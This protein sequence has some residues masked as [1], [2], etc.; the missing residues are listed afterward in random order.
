MRFVVRMVL[1]FPHISK[2]DTFLRCFVGV[3]YKSIVY[4]I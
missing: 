1:F 4:L 3:E 2:T